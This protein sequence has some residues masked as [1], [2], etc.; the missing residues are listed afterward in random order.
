MHAVKG[1]LDAIVGGLLTLSGLVL[2]VLEILILFGVVQGPT[3][4]DLLQVPTARDLLQDPTAPDLLKATVWD[5][6][7]LLLDRAKW[8]I[9]VGLL[10]I[11]GGVR[12]LSVQLLNVGRS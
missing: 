9:V 8:L 6:L 4:G 3:A 7:I 2:V 10:L 12:V 5:F 1:V 11:Y